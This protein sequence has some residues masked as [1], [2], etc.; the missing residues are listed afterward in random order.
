MNKFRDVGR[1][2]PLTTEQGQY[3]LDRVVFAAR[4]ELIGRRLLPIRKIDDGTATFGYDTLTEA[5]DAAID[6]GWPGRETLDIVNLARTTV[7][8]PVIH[9]EFLIN[10]L[11]L[12]ASRQTGTPLNTTTAESAGYKVGLEEDKLVI[13][14]YTKDGT[15]YDINGLYKAAG[16]EDTTSYTWSSAPE[17]ATTGICASINAA[18][19]LLMADNIFPPYNL[20]I[21]PTQYNQAAVFITNTAVP[22]LTWIKERIGGEIYPTATMTAGT[23]MITKAN[24]VG[25]FEYVVAEDFTVS[26]EVMSVREGSGLFGRVYARGLPVVYDSNAICRSTVLGG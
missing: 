26:T 16:N 1:D 23:G 11:D 17:H 18:I 25:M 22:Y 20:C 2:E 4:R 13:I 6:I 9:K 10:K 19:T 3:I 14:G 8:V 7:P 24:P 21:H 5:A 12:A 15:T